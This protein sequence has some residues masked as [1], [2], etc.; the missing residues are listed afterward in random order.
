MIL[1]LSTDTTLYY[2]D[3]IRI[4]S[5]PKELRIVAV[6]DNTTAVRVLRWYIL[7]IAVV[8]GLIMSLVIYILL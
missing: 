1:E 8:M 7:T 5:R 4:Y 3:G 6:K 2:T